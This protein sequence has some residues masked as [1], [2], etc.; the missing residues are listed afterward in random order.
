MQTRDLN[1]ASK[2][3]CG[4][5]VRGSRV[6]SAPRRAKSRVV[7]HSTR[8][9]MNFVHVETRARRAHPFPS[10]LSFSVLTRSGAVQP[11]TSY[12][13]MHF[14]AN[15]FRRTSVPAAIAPKRA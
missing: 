9:D 2:L 10:T 8:D 15:C 3:R 4:D 1:E 12:S 11:F 13:A 5:A 6:S 14:S 7:L